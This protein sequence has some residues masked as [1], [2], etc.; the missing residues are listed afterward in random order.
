MFMCN[1]D[2][3][4]AVALRALTQFE[5]ILSRN[6]S[7]EKS[8]LFLH[9]AGRCLSRVIWTASEIEQSSRGQLPRRA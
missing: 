1:A 3:V 5:I 2:D 4:V 8:D 6:G 9:E 7:S